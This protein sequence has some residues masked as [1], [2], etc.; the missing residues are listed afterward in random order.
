MVAEAD[1]PDETTRHVDPTASQIALR[2]QE[3]TVDV[4]SL[5]TG[6]LEPLEFARELDTQFELILDINKALETDLL[7]A[8]EELRDLKRRNAQ[9]EK[10]LRQATNDI[11]K[12]KDLDD[13]LAKTR[14][15]Y[16][17]LL[18]QIDDTKQQIE[19]E[20]LSIKKKDDKIRRLTEIQD[21]LKYETGVLK[22]RIE[23][24]RAEKGEI[25]NRLQ[26]V[27][28]DLRDLEEQKKSIDAAVKAV[29]RR[30]NA[31]K[32][33]ILKIKRTLSNVLMA[34]A[35]T[36]NKARLQFGKIKAVEE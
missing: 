34:F 20:E 22:N 33:N 17:E 21:R 29:R 1:R 5:L 14:A 25:G 28:F 10:L 24:V 15:A 4:D 26:G 2:D 35:N 19:R 32:D 3:L 8:R 27:Y 7:E 9:V 30:T 13:R 16:E 6:E 36:Q 12:G 31:T 18:D 11:K 23:G